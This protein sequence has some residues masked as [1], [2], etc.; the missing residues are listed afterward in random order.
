MKRIKKISVTPLSDTAGSIIDSLYSGSNEV[1]NAPSIR[2][3]KAALGQTLYAS[4]ASGSGTSYRYY[5]ITDASLPAEPVNGMTIKVTFPATHSAY[6][7]HL[8]L[9]SGTYHQCFVQDLT[10]A[11]GTNSYPNIATNRVYELIYFNNSWYFLSAFQKVK[12]D[13]IDFATFNFANE[14][15]IGVMGNS[16]I[17]IRTFSGNFPSSTSWGVIGNIGTNKT[18]LAAF[19]AFADGNTWYFFP[20]SGGST[21]TSIYYDGGSGNVNV[22]T[23]DWPSGKPIRVT[24]MYI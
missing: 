12:S 21:E 16:P 10:G 22:K 4:V 20:S 24:V 9:N 7:V 15:Q 6:L 14:T 19:G 11:A 13:N 23:Y 3:V 18:L 5:T 2:A 1:T 8:R 17:K